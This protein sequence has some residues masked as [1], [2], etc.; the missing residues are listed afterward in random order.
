MYSKYCIARINLENPFKSTLVNLVHW[1]ESL[2][3]KWIVQHIL[4]NY[5]IEADYETHFIFKISIVS[6]QSIVIQTENPMY[7]QFQF[8]NSF[9]ALFYTAFYLQDID[10]LK[11]VYSQKPWG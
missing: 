10:K 6:I 11:E 5:K 8:V 9:L 2:N 4:E 1:I 3:I 7:F